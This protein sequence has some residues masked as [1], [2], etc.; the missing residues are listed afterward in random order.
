MKFSTKVRYALRFM[1]NLA[2]HYKKNNNTKL[3][4]VAKEEDI[5]IKYLEQIVMTLKASGLLNVARG[6]NG[7]Y[8]LSKSPE[9][10]KLLEIIE[11]INGNISI[12]E[13]ITNEEV[14]GKQTNCTTLREVWNPLNTMIKNF[15]TNMTLKDLVDSHKNQKNMYYI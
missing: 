9:K 4:E 13:C 11:T 14:C 12:I 2:L 1:L 10:I 15:F 5:S 3:N 7:G 6:A 8:A